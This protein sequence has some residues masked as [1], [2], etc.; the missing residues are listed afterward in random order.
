VIIYT[1]WK[2]DEAYIADYQHEETWRGLQ[3]KELKAVVP[4]LSGTTQ[5]EPLKE[6]LS[7]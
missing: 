6:I 7:L 3:K 4:H 5:D 1:L 2:K